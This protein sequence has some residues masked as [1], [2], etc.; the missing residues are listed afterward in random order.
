MCHTPLKEAPPTSPPGELSPALLEQWCRAVYPLRDTLPLSEADRE[1]H[2]SLLAALYWQLGW[3]VGVVSRALSTNQINWG[4]FLDHSPFEPHCNQHPNNFI[5]LPPV[6]EAAPWSTTHIMLC[7]PQ[8]QS[9]FLAPVDFDLAFTADRFVSPYS[10]TND[11]SLFRSWLESG[12]SEMERGLG[13]EQVN[14]GLNE[15]VKV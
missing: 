5:V 3:E 8:G 15:G 11:E 14:T 2:G 6:S 12:H 4:Y 13:G 7:F 9:T 10:G 1:N